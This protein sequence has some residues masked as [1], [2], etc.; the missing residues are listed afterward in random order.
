[1]IFPCHYA[2]LG[3]GVLRASGPEDK[4]KR[5]IGAAT[6]GNYV[7]FALDQQAGSECT[8]AST[9]IVQRRAKG[10]DAIRG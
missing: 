3:L 6:L 8:T 7:R 1:M 9:F 5:R 2:L 10:V 4:K